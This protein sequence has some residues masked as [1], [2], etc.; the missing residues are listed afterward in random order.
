VSEHRQNKRHAGDPDAETCLAKRRLIL[1]AG[2]PRSGTTPV[3]NLLSKCKGAVSIYEP[4]GET[5]LVRINT[6]FPV[7]GDGLGLSPSDLEQLIEDLAAFRF[8]PLKPQAR[9]GREPS[10][11]TRLFGSRTLHSMRLARL[12]PWARTV[13]WKDP[14]AIMLVPDLVDTKVDIVVTMRTPRAH[15]ASY[16]RLGWQAQ[17]GKIYPRWSARFGRC[18]VCESMLERSNDS[19]VSAAL[20]WR[21]SYLPLVLTDAITGVHLITSAALEAD[22]RIAYHRLVRDLALTPTLRMERVLSQSRRDA[23]LSEMSSNTHD[24][25][26]SLTSVNNYWRE[27][28]T[29]DEIDVVDAITSDL[30]PTFFDK[31]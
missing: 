29:K 27:L 18:R 12:K 14:H 17:A 31:P 10:V 13:I 4:L 3:G 5:G 30:V 28:L 7:V 23:G 9:R 11:F 2:A 24:W 25:T 21:M 22:E 6:R 15:A 19:V 26:R 20:L 1:V 8:G 16:K